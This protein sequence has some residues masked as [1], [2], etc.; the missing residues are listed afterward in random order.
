MGKMTSQIT[1]PLRGPF[2]KCPPDIMDFSFSTD[3]DGEWYVVHTKSRRE[4]KLAAQCA[5]SGLVHYLPLRKSITGNRGRRYISDVPLFPG[6]IFAF[7][8]RTGRQFL[9]KTGHVANVLNVVDQEGLLKD[10]RNIRTVCEEQTML[11]PA[12]FVKKGQRV[13]VVEGPLTGVEGIVKGYKGRYRLVLEIDCIQQ[14]VACEIDIRM[15][16]PI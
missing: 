15:V 12:S 2:Q 4:K 11:E 8:D 9:F 10:L 14:A 16:V 13:Q 1:L 3:S 6:Y 5:N 7:G